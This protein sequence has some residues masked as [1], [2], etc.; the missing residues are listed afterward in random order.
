MAFYDDA[1][2]LLYAA[3]KGAGKSDTFREGS[4]VTIDYNDYGGDSAGGDAPPGGGSVT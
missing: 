2:G 4:G 3:F 1:S